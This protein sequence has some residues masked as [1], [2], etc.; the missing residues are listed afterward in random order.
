MTIQRGNKG[1][2]FCSDRRVL[3]LD[4]SEINIYL[5]VLKFRTLHRQQQEEENLVKTK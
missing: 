3:Y 5:Y 2:F 1:V 4:C